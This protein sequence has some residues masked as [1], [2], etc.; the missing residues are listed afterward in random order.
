MLLK[1]YGMKIEDLKR[2]DDNGVRSFMSPITPNTLVAQEEP[3]LPTEVKQLNPHGGNSG[4][5]VQ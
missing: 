4:S 1:S 3:L 5:P 2:L